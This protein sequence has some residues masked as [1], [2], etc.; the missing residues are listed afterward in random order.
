[1]ACLSSYTTEIF[2]QLF[3][4]FCSIHSLQVLR[5]GAGLSTRPTPQSRVKVRTRGYL[6]SG[7]SVD[8]H[9]SLSFTVGDGDV[10]QAWDLVVPLMEKGETAQI[11]TNSR[12]AY[13]S[14]GK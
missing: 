6:E 1:M 8:R 5:K 13:G 10:V 14:L 7:K 2:Y 12:F 11:K 4:Y 9:S 3:I